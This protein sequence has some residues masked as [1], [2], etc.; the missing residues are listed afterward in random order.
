MAVA[1]CKDEDADTPR[2]IGR[3]NGPCVRCGTSVEAE[4][5]RRFGRDARDAR[6]VDHGRPCRS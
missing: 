5:E 6:R 3:T 4:Y 1:Y 2:D